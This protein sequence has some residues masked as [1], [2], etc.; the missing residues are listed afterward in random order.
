MGDA[1]TQA[2]TPAYR[3]D[4]NRD[5][6]IPLAAV[7]EYLH[8]RTDKR[9]KR[10]HRCVAYR[11]AQ[12][13]CRADDGTLI[14]LPTTRI[15]GVRHSSLEALAWF[16]AALDGAPAAA[17][18]ARAAAAASDAEDEATLRRAGVA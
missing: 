17:A 9:R 1:Q 8:E 11:W 16:S 10:L 12:R 5:K 13:G 6:L 2:P 7:S 3:I 18:E 14:R 4:I 15:G